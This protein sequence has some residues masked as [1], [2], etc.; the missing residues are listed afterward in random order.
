MVVAID[1]ILTYS[2]YFRVRSQS[3]YNADEQLKPS[4]HL[5][6]SNVEPS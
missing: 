3:V 1:M 4:S 6:V 5:P 2:V